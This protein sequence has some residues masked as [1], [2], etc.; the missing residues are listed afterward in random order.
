LEAN[1]DEMETKFN[2]LCLESNERP[3]VPTEEDKMTDVKYDIFD[4]ETLKYLQE[5]E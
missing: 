4:E 3:L 2:N 5:R 1:T